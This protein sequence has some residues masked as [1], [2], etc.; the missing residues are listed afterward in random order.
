M[1][2]MSKRNP[3]YYETLGIPSNAKHNDVG[4]AFNRKM[5]SLRRED[6]P[7]DL[8]GETV[9]REAFETLSDLDR[10]EK[11][12]AKLRADI[13]KPRLGRNHAA[14]AVLFLLVVGVGLFLYRRP[15][16]ALEGVAGDGS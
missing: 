14:S 8:K 9:L 1:A 15:Q 6:V 4:L 12:D 2:P 13:L 11:Y 3:T 5:R 7:P 10:R 16:L